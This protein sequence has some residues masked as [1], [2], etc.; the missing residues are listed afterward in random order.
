V[1]AFKDSAGWLIGVIVNSWFRL[2]AKNEGCVVAGTD[3]QHLKWMHGWLVLSVC[4]LIVFISP[5]FIG[6][7]VLHP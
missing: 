3:G 2:S 5:T 1:G 6:L 4:G 7:M